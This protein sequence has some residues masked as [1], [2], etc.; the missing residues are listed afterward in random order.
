MSDAA[1]EVLAVL[2]DGIESSDK[3]MREVAYVARTSVGQFLLGELPDALIRV[4]LG[5][6]A[7]EADEVKAVN[8]AAELLD[9]P[10]L[11]GPSSIPKK[12]DMAAQVS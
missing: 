4:Q 2:P 9:E 5:S 8:A 3:G 11:M 1:A 6:V 7:R 10:S 12:E